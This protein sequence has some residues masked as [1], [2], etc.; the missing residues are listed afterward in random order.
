MPTVKQLQRRFKSEW[1][2]SAPCPCGS[3]KRF[4]QCCRAFDGYPRPRKI[5]IIPPGPPTGFGH[6]RCYLRSTENC[7]QT[8]SREHPIS[9]GLL[10]HLQKS[11]PDNRLLVRGLHW[12][13]EDQD[14]A[15]APNALASA[16]LCKRHNENISPLDDAA[17]HAYRTIEFA[18]TLAAKTLGNAG[19][20]NGPALERFILKAVAGQHFG[21]TASYKREK[22]L[23]KFDIDMAPFLEAL[24]H[25]RW[26]PGCGLYARQ[27]EEVYEF[28]GLQDFP[29]LDLATFKIIGCTLIMRGIAMTVV[30]NT[31]RVLWENDK[32]LGFRPH[33]LV[34]DGADIVFGW[35]GRPSF[36]QTW[37]AT[38]VEGGALS[39][40]TA[41]GPVDWLTT[42]STFRSPS[43][44][45]SSDGTVV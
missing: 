33:H 9:K 41:K 42:A 38:S 6:P 5:S 1:A 7:C 18:D 17:L 12:D 24:I 25:D 35:D 20:I 16:V 43:K 27:M 45:S 37:R 44:R 22:T 30:F 2:R 39:S 14:R 26:L 28:K 13:V 31:P 11:S 34:A 15:Y 3:N 8:I 36:E 23:G 40:M 19:F 10:E 29:Y 4:S 32:P 21:G